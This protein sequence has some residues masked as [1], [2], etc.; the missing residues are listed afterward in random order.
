MRPA[1]RGFNAT[2]AYEPCGFGTLAQ[3]QAG[4]A[5]ETGV[6]RCRIRRQSARRAVAGAVAHN[7]HPLDVGLGRA[8]DMFLPDH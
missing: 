8:R 1:G 7:M 5:Q 3:K 2:R 4:F 6:N